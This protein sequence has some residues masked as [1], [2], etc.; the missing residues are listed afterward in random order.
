M[1]AFVANVTL[2]SSAAHTT[3]TSTSPTSAPPTTTPVT[4]TS[5]APT[6]TLA[7]VGDTQLGNTPQLPPDPATYFAPVRAALAAPIVFGN[8]EGTMTSA[9]TSK[10]SARSTECYAFKVPTAYA[11]IYRAAGFTVLNSA[12]NHAWDFGPAGVASTSAALAAAGIAQAGLPGQIALVSEAGV[13][14]AFVDF[15]PY[16][17]TN[18]MLEAAS[19]AALIERAR[20]E[21]N[22]VVVYMHTG[23]EGSTADHVTRASEYFYGEN[24]GNPYAFAHAAI[25]DG[26]DLVIGSGPHVLRGLEWYKGHV[27]AYSLGD[28]TNYYDFA[29]S[30][31]LGLSAILHVTL[32]ANGRFVSGRFTSVRLASDGQASLDPAKSAAQFVNA[33]S[34]HDF[35]GSAVMVGASGALIPPR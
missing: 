10:C 16:Y 7:A 8:L 1:V 6:V 18:N 32:S 35:A 26:A 9:T 5:V 29:T 28:F 2:R 21:A 17:N 14:V 15:A 4:T 25:D 20:R 12:N 33:L 24:R 34:R 23:A 22:V 19:A 31:N 30:G 3:V 27:I 11:Q 13:R